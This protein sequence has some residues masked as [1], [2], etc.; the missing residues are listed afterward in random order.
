VLCFKAFSGIR[1]AGGAPE[2][3]SFSYGRSYDSVSAI[4]SSS[5]P[6]EPAARTSFR[7]ESMT[8]PSIR[9]QM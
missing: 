7:I 1:L 9:F 6:P 2:S 4:F 5:I 3:H 8:K